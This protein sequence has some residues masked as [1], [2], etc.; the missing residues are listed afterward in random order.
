MTS[1]I[2][3]RCCDASCQNEYLN[4]EEPCWGRIAVNDETVKWTKDTI[5][6]VH[7][8]HACEGHIY[9]PYSPPPTEGLRT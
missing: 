5:R 6:V 2:T 7:V 4:K 8:G 3:D 9:F 1:E